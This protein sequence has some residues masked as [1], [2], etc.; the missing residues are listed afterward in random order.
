MSSYSSVYENKS[1]LLWTFKWNIA[2]KIFAPIRRTRLKNKDFTVICNNC[3]AAMAIYQRLGLRYNTPTVG[4]F[5]YAEDYIRFLEGFN[6]YV[7]EPLRFKKESRH[8]RTQDFFRKFHKY[9]I[10][11]LGND[12]EI[13]FNH[14]KNEEEAE[15]KWSRRIARINFENLFFVFSDRDEFQPQYLRRFEILPYENKIFFSCKPWPAAKSV[16]FVKDY[17]CD[18]QVGDAFRERVYEKYV[19]IV[20]WL[21]DGNI[22]QRKI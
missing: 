14:Y 5:F 18:S 13:H 11:V 4:L 17:E 16:V 15:E 19:D 7:N 22:F 21:N 2:N 8:L 3:F 12:I 20:K 9:P 1:K 10:G 6:E